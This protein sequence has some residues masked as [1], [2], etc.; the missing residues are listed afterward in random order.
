MTGRPSD[1]TQELAD[2]ICGRLAE[3]ESLRAICETEG[4]PNKSTVFRWLA[5]RTDFRDQYAR[6]RELQAETLVDE[7]IEISDDA[8]NDYMANL[9]EGEE[10]LA[11]RLNGE[12]VQRSRLRV[13]SRKWFASKVA[14]K[15]YGDRVT[16][17]LSGPDGG[18]MEIITG[19]KDLLGA[20]LNRALASIEPGAVSGKS[21]GS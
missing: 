11:Y 20:K 3:G 15:K 17:E 12:H 7:I 10:T 19:A 21:D 4:L 13:D 8:R 5:S 18:P 6:A 1:F 16:Q 14:A 9:G 2:T